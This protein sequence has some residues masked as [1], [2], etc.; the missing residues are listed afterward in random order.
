[1]YILDTDVVSNLRKKKPHPTLLG[2]TL[3]PHRASRN[4]S[5]GCWK[6]AGPR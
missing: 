6:W 5:A 1:V 3:R 4:G 2:L